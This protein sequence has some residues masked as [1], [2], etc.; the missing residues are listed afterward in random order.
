[1]IKLIRKKENQRKKLFPIFGKHPNLVYL[2]N[3]ASTQKPKVVIDWVSDFLRND[4]AN[5]HR[6]LYSLSEKSEELYYESK[7]ARKSN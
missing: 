3:A 6:G 7:W 1:M 2:D 4:Y 5:I